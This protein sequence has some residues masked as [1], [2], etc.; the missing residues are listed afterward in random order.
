LWM[1]FSATFSFFGNRFQSN[2]AT[3]TAV[4]GTAEVVGAT[5]TIVANQT[6][7][8]IAGQ[9]DTDGDG[10]TNQHE[11]GIGTDP[12]NA[13]TDRDGL[14]DGQE[15]L[16]L[17]TNPLNPDTDGDGLTDGDEAKRGT[18]PLNLDTDGDG[19]RDGDEVR[20][21]TNPLKQDTDGD[22]LIDSAEPG[23]CPNPLNPD[24]DADG[25]IDG[26][27]LSPCD[28]SNPALTATGVAGQP[29]ASFTPP[30]V[31]VPT[32]TPSPLPV[33]PTV[34]SIPILNINWQWTSVTQQATNQTTPVPD[35]NQYT[36]VFKADGT[37]SGRVDCNTFN[38]TFAQNNG[39]TIRVTTVTQAICPEGSLEQQYLQLLANVASG[40]P[41][42]TGNL[43][44]ETSAG[45]ERMLFRNGGTLP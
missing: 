23:P 29:T 41:D 10:L 5:Q 11:Q 22:G 16:R 6:A 26:R 32:L 7:A 43:A 30:P 34:T 4:A 25:I 40:G 13:D 33:V 12:N 37:V 3:Q 28:A 36:L 19:L 21:G 39:L 35:P 20:I 44:L 45:A 2:S 42:G 9:Q 1:G 31:I 38:G 27:D 14:L 24:S 18:N 15:V 17:G 8:A